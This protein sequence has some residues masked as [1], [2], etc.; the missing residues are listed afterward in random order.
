[1]T[2]PR[3]LSRLRS[4]PA[5][6]VDRRLAPLKLRAIDLLCDRFGIDSLADLGAAWGVEGGYAFY[7]AERWDLGRVVIVDENLKRY[8]VIQ[9]RAAQTPA[10]EL[11]EGNFG[12]DGVASLVKRVDAVLMFDVLL[13]QVSPSD[14]RQVLSLYAPRTE[15]FAMVGP[16]WRDET[17]TRLPDLGRDRYL[18]LVPDLRIHAEL[19]DRIEQIN[20]ERGLPWRDCQDVWQWGISD[21]DLRRTM[22]ELGFRLAQFEDHGTWSYPDARGLERRLGEFFNGLYLFVRPTLLE[23]A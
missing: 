6:P 3:V 20:P 9:E 4:K 19:F 23:R 11:V 21:S 15:L 10:V 22:S 8:P 18:E 5:R 14:W 16:W 17:T 7:A 1:V 2:L 12:N 13:H